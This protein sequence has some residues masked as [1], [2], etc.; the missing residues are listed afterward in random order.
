MSLADEIDKLNQ[1]KESGALTEEEFQ[2]GKAAT[3]DVYDRISICKGP[4]LGTNF[5]LLC[6][7]VL[8]AHYDELEWAEELGASRNLSR[9]SVGLEA[10]EDLIARLEEGLRLA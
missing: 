9:L 1:L 7:Y 10:S 4:S 2:Q 6:P 5:S 3:P 8:L